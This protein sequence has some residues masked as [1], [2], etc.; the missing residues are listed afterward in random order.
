[1]DFRQLLPEPKTVDL[2]ALLATLSPVDP[3][4]AER[5]YTFVNFISSADGRAAFGGRSAPL[6][7]DGDRDMFHGL[8]EQVDAVLV[9][10]GTLRS[11]RYGRILRKPE[12]RQRRIERG[13]KPEPIACIVTRSGD[14]P[15]AAPLFSEPEAHVVIFSAVDIDVG[16]CAAQVEVAVLDPGELTQTTALRRLRA[17]YEVRTLLCEGGPTLF[18]ALLLESVVDEL[19]L[20][21]APKLAGGGTEPTITSGPELAEPRDME[22]RWLLERNGSLFLRYAVRSTERA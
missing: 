10:T 6:G 2:Q 8:R 17:D 1:M 15:L 14:V 3:I 5:P 22:I 4:P 7:D 13:W 12:R 18:G 21:L 11:E 9:G 20:T 19:F 16:G